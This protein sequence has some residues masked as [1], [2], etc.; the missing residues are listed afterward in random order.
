ME[1]CK[2][3]KDVFID[4][5]YLF[6]SIVLACTIVNIVYMHWTILDIN[7]LFLYSYNFANH[8]F[9]LIDLIF[10][11]F[12]C[13]IFIRKKLYF[14]LIPYFISLIYLYINILYS[15]YFNAYLP[16][17][18]Y[19][20]YNNLNGLTSNVFAAIRLKDYILLLTTIVVVISYYQF[21]RNGSVKNKIIIP[22]ILFSVIGISFT[23]YY[24]KEEIENRRLKEHFKE[25]N[26][27]RSV[28]TT[29]NDNICSSHK[30]TNVDAF[31][32][33][34]FF[35][36]L[37]LEISDKIQI[38][39]KIDLSHVKPYLYPSFYNIEN[40]EL[41]KNLILII[42]ESF[43]SYPIGKTF[44]GI[45]ITPSLN[46]LSE[47][48]YYH[49]K[50]CSETKLGESSDGQ[51]IYLTGLLP[52]NNKVT[53]NEIDA[54]NLP[55]IPSFLKTMNPDYK[56]RM[57]IPTDSKMWGQKEMCKK[58]SIDELYS[59]DTYYKKIDGWLTDE[60]LFDY[61][62]EIDEKNLDTKFMSVVLSSSTHSPYKTKL[63]NKTINFPD[64]FSNEFKNYLYNIH[65]A[66]SCLG[67]YLN[68]LKTNGLFDK[69]III[70]VSDHKPN[71]PQLNMF[72][73]NIC[74]D[75]PLFII[76]NPIP[77]NF[78]PS[79]LYQS[80]LFPTIIDIMGLNTQWKGVGKSLL[81]PDSIMKLDFEV[82]RKVKE[83]EIS[84]LL[85]LSDFKDIN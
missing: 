39:D 60:E 38:H 73:S 22:L 61:A 77:M 84:E 7:S 58:Y 13:F 21:A 67:N 81:M 6:I 29:I 4:R 69:S 78:T 15:R 55:A 53:I 45:E 33:Y 47:E 46:R 35:I 5:T 23:R 10:I 25:L 56:I 79:I 12:L 19:L 28:W 70:I 18:L 85:L 20:E 40:R 48:Y 8:T 24:I 66:D 76:N 62:L 49:S 3:N 71:L 1:L 9:I 14:Y 74:N 36:N 2:K 80:T 27:N 50:M 30:F 83:Q 72:N 54:S 11:Y 59:T 37:I 26:D 68:R 16:F 82:I 44:D 43:C 34:G 65:Y 51:F 17:S 31:F 52:L 57:V 75:L 41:S 32:N 64:S 42:L 63:V